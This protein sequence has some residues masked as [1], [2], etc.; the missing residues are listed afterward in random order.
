MAG[1]EKRMNSD[2]KIALIRELRDQQVR[3]APRNKRSEQAD[4]AEK[5]LTELDPAKDYPFDFLFYRVTEVRPDA[6]SMRLIKGQDALH[7]LRLF[8]ED[9]TDSMNLRLEEASE[10]VH[11]VEDLSKRFNVSTKTISR[12]RDQGLVSRRFISEGR[13]RV[14]FLHS[15]VERFVNQNKVR[16]ERGERFSQMSDLERD[17]IIDRARRL[18]TQGENLTEVIRQVSREVQRSV[19]TIRYTIKNFDRRFPAMAVFPEQRETLSEEDKRALYQQHLR[20]VSTI[21]LGKR[22]KRTRSSIIRI[23]SE[24]RALRIKELALDFVP[25]P[26]FDKDSNVHE[27]LAETPNAVS[28]GRK[29]RAPAG[30]PAYLAS[31]YEVPLLEPQQEVHL[32]RKMNFLKYKASKLLD[33]LDPKAPSIALMDQ[34]EKLYEDALAVKNKIVQANLRLVVSIAK[35]HVGASGDLFGLI[36]DGN[37]SLMRAVDKFDYTRGFKFSTY[38][39]WAIRKN[40]ARSIPDE[41]KHRERFR[42]S[43]EEIF[44][45]RED[46]RADYLAVEIDQ[47]SRAD[48]VGKILH[49]LDEREQQIIVLRFGLGQGSEPRTLKEVG[50]EL[51]VTKERIRQLELRALAKLRNAAEREKIDEPE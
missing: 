33:K 28:P 21:M 29:M 35:R 50:E 8:V 26:E 16:V 44:Q 32:F 13:K 5:L 45:S 11:T 43:S 9:I 3:F 7:D 38:A 23:L 20:G 12:W 24:Q 6:H 1:G 27:I 46:A 31:L 48:Q 10:P 19:E 41:F 30:L 49:T 51:G 17:D 37:V 39:H 4:R 47:Q 25:S 2:Y 40:F 36:S 42:T 22:Y 15:S 34:I 18:S 14:G